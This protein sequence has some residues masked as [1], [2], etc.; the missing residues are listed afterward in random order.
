MSRVL[1]STVKKVKGPD[2]NIHIVSLYPIF[3]IFC[4]KCK[5]GIVGPISTK[6]L[7]W[8]MHG[9]ITL[10]A[11]LILGAGG[12]GCYALVALHAG[13]AVLPNLAYLAL[14]IS[15]LLWIRLGIKWAEAQ[16]NFPEMREDI[17]FFNGGRSHDH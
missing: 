5:G 7:L 12:V 6:K 1:P 13:E 4:I 16:I 14:S 9:S 2:M 10:T 11:L 8:V 15:S 3:C 17:D